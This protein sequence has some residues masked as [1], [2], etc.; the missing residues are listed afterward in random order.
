MY[1]AIE[2]VSSLFL[3]GS[4]RVVPWDFQYVLDVDLSYLFIVGEPFHRV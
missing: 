4:L 3:S 2:I 1:Y